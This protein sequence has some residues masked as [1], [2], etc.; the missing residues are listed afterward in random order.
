MRLLAV[1]ALAAAIVAA[2]CVGAKTQTP[3]SSAPAASTAASGA[4]SRNASAS[5]AAMNT[6][7]MG[8]ASMQAPHVVTRVWNGTITGAGYG[9]EENRVCCFYQGGPTDVNT[10]LNVSIGPGASFL[11]ITLAWADAMS[12]LDLQVIAPDFQ[13][14]TIPVNGSGVTTH[15]GHYWINDNGTYAAGDSPAR[16][17]VASPDAFAKSGDWSITVGAKNAVQL[18]FTVTVQVWYGGRPSV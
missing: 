12:D 16:V 11:R 10:Q 18:P 15:T 2:G 7:G 3:A 9:N 8:A 13:E 4:V 17:Q 14:N 1:L 6:S 5:P